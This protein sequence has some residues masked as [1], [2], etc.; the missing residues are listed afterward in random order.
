[1]KF[2]H[3]IQCAY[4]LLV[5][6][7][8][9]GCQ[10]LEEDPKSELTPGNYL[11]NEVEMEGAVA[12]MYSAF[13][14]STSGYGTTF[15]QTSYFGSDD[16]TTDPGLNK[17]NMRD[18][19]RFAGTSDNPWSNRQWTAPWSTIT[20]AN[21]ILDNIEG[22]TASQTYLDEAA[23][24]AYFMR[25]MCYYYMVRTYGKVPIVVSS[26][27][28][29]S[30]QPDRAPVQD[31]YS[32]IIS[33]LKMAETLLPRSFDSQPGKAT[34]LAATSL[35]ADVYL[36]MTGHPLN[37]TSKYVLSAA[38]AKT[39]MGADAYTLVASYAEVFQ[40]NGN[41]EAIFA[42]WHNV[43]GGM[44]NRAFGSTATPLEEKAAS[45]SGGWQDFYA[46]I[47]FFENAPVCSRTDDTFYTTLKIRQDDG[48]TNLVDWDDL[49]TRVRHPYYQ[50]FRAGLGDGVVETDT[51]I[52]EINPSTNKNF[53]VIRYP[54]V[55]L[56]YAESSA[57]AGSGPTAESYAAIN[58]VRNRAGLPPLTP[59]LSQ[60]DFRDAVV[61]ERAYEFAAEF[62]IR[63]FD[64]VRLQ[65]LPEVLAARN[66]DVLII[67][68]VEIPREN[69]PSA[70]VLADETNFYL[71]PIPNNEMSRNPD[72][73][74]N[75]GYGR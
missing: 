38:A 8:L 55:L 7:S 16:I 39:V 49:S 25:G 40:T 71:A 10:D 64:I 18:F 22:V 56:N 13:A 72:W 50:K 48:T 34:D 21:F 46:E 60:I 41:S 51:E 33:D 14:L 67:D 20:Q 2:K 28:D 53:D 44:R 66:K 70:A 36:T 42:T 63:W 26:I 45:G 75:P 61:Y 31:V 12:S 62:G 58:E 17:A 4:A 54:A 23:G 24:Q 65:L 35:L 59:G 37:D 74:Q 57:M 52:L 19:D 1:M 32:L 6:L 43:D 73:D 5:L 29:L 11:N 69:P 15:K 9:V 47:T 27:F 3:S 68:G 30:V